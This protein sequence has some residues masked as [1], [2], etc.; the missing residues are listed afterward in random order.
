MR[1]RDHDEAMAELFKDDPV[2]AAEYL[3]QVLQDGEPADLLVAL[4]QMAQAHGGVRVLAK[5]AELNATQLY[6]T[7]SP[8]GNPELRSLSAVLNALG[9]RLAV[10]PA[11]PH[12]AAG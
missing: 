9:L 5:E 1:D 4:R 12:V 6:R 11:Q 2:F 7:L 3:N 8:K 10:Q